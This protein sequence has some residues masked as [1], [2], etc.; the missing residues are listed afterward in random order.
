MAK[1]RSTARHPPLWILSLGVGFVGLGLGIWIPGMGWLATGILLVA[2][3]W[4]WLLPLRRAWDR[5][6]E[7]PVQMDRLTG[8]LA[9]I[10]LV[11]AAGA[12]FHLTGGSGWL[13]E[14]V[15]QL[16]WDA[17]AALGEIIGAVGQIL[18]AIVA[19]F[20]AWR[21]YVISRD[22]TL[23][24]NLITQQ[25]T[26][27]TYFQGISD[28]VLD[29]QGQLEDW[30]LER[31]IAQGRTAAILTGLDPAGKAK[32]LRFLSTANL[33]SPLR[34]DQHLGRPI[35]DGRGGYQRDRQ[36][37][38]RVIDLKT[39]LEGANLSNT[40]L[41]GVDLSAVSL[42]GANLRGCDLSYANLSGANLSEADLR[43]AILHKTLLYVGSLD[44]ASPDRPKHTPDFKTGD[45]AGAIVHNCR[46]TGAQNLSDDQ[47]HY[48]CKWGGPLTQSTIP[49][50]CALLPAT[51]I[52]T[53]P[54]DPLNPDPAEGLNDPA[55]S[56]S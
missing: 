27:D 39:F 15:T 3:G 30:P 31:A 12:V 50:G 19:A 41:R 21:Q 9:L 8:L 5:I 33:L 37:G 11:I 23:Q 26:I 44:T 2:G 14:Q 34:R 18:I 6:Q 51:P 52:L 7:D 48:L 47:R 24:Q 32:I 46:L 43:G 4:R 40:D 42:E 35:L 22:L 25:Q 38:I 28:L 29:P 1:T 10:A 55:E 56:N 53:S 16:G 54:R 36:H 17:V 45:G 13:T 49:G 20:I